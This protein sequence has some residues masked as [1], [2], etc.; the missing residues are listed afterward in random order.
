M[1][2]ENL[3]AAFVEHIRI[4]PNPFEE[5][6]TLSFENSGNTSYELIIRDLSGKL[7]QRVE[8]IRAS[9]VK[10]YKENKAK[11]AYLWELKG[12]KVAR[13]ILMIE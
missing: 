7:V 6:C 11:G 8:H 12:E 3:N 10:I 4:Q 13:G 1:A 2:S 5:V 9:E